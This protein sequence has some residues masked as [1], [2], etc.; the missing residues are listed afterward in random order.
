MSVRHRE[1]G[2]QADELY[3][4]LCMKLGH[5]RDGP[6]AARDGEELRVPWDRTGEL[7]R[8]LFPRLRQKAFS[9][10]LVT[11]RSW[12][13]RGEFFE[14]A[15]A[16]ARRGCRIEIAFLL[17]DRYL[18]ADPTLRKHVRRDRD[19]GI[20]TLVLDVSDLLNR[21]DLPPS[22]TLAFGLWDGVLSCS[23]GYGAESGPIEWRVSVSEERA[24]SYRRLMD[25]LKT[26]ARRLSMDGGASAEL[27]EPL[28]LSVPVT[29]ILAPVLCR[30]DGPARETCRWTH[31]VWPYL[32]LFRMA[33]APDRH[34]RFLFEAL[35]AL[36]RTGEFPRVLISATCD[37]AMLAH[38]V[39]AYGR[40]KAA[41][42]VTVVDRCETPLALCRW[43][44]KLIGRRVET[45]AA[46]IFRYQASAPF[47]VICTDSLL[48]RFP[49]GRRR[50]LAARWRALLRPGGKV[51]TATRLEPDWTPPM[52]CYTT[53]Q[54]RLL[55]ERVQQLAQRWREFLHVDPRELAADAR[56]VARET[57][58][59]SL[60]SRPEVET[61]FMRAGF[62][63]DRFT[64]AHVAEYR[65][66]RDPG[67][68][69]RRN[70]MFAQ[71]VASRA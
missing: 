33:P 23:A 36:A 11:G 60:R 54:K 2:R 16:A 66:N 26:E 17:P 67:T 55:G 44:A 52:A 42:D 24:R 28:M 64:L 70:R 38:L 25:V 21:L 34:A 45:Q 1:S 40:E 58:T 9:T 30:P 32:R 3:R 20:R 53:R 14:A 68:R 15:R 35:G 18:R 4:R 7:G 50:A 37:Y 46:D 49:S 27:T 47:D 71:I 56:R 61:L 22:T 63:F 69:R 8:A 57:R 51:I 19:A 5:G 12:N 13:Y 65:S 62:S 41:L 59:Y 39:Y 6:G 31:G 48:S 10:L 43:Y 29:R